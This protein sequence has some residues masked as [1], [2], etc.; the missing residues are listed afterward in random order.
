MT[1][2]LDRGDQKLIFHGKSFMSGFSDTLWNGADHF[3]I[4]R[5]V[6]GMHAVVRYKPPT[7]NKYAGEVAELE[8]RQELA[9]TPESKTA[10]VETK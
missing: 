3:S 4:C 9:T 2:E 10:T 1:L 8:F 5:H 7:D 6:E